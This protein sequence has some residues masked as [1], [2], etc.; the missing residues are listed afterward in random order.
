[1]SI[2]GCSIPCFPFEFLSSCPCRIVEGVVQCRAMFP[3]AIC[4]A[5]VTSVE[6][7]P[8]LRLSLLCCALVKLLN[9]CRRG[10]A[11]GNASA[12]LSVY[13][14]CSVNQVVSSVP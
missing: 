11:M 10:F 2:T 14:M 12:M 5:G 9:C 4:G 13:C 7:L 8:A 1:M 6:I 3:G